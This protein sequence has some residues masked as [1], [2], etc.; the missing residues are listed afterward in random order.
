MK[1]TIIISAT[2]A[3][4]APLRRLFVRLLYGLG[5]KIRVIDGSIS[6]CQFIEAEG[7]PP[8]NDETH[9]LLP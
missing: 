2:E 5:L 1:V 4:G 9:A 3:E 8:T 6:T 7:R